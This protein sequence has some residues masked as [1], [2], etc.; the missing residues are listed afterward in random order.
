VRLGESWTKG[1]VVVSWDDVRAGAADT[2]HGHNVILHEFAHQLDEED[3]T[4]DGM[5]SLELRSR[6]VPWARMISNEFKKLRSAAERGQR[7]DIDIYGATNPA[8]FFA[9][10]TEAFFERPH[11]LRRRHPELYAE[12]KTFYRQDPSTFKKRQE[13][14]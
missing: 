7:T 5:P 8:E 11:A 9:V 14:R 2:A 6:Y 4:A 12:L 3:G 10:I 1:V 13:K